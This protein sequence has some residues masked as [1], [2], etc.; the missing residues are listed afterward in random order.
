[1]FLTEWREFPSAV[2]LAEKIIDGSRR[3]VEIAHIA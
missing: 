3:D 1:M 2:C